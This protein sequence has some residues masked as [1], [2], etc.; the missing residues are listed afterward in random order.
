MFM[1]NL[2]VVFVP[3]TEISQVYIPMIVEACDYGEGKV[4]GEDWI[5]TSV[6]PDRE[7]AYAAFA[8]DIIAYSPV[9]GQLG[10]DITTFPIMAPVVATRDITA[11]PMTVVR[12]L[13]GQEYYRQ[14]SGPYGVKCVIIHGA[15]YKAEHAGLYEAGIILGA[16]DGEPAYAGYEKLVGK[17]G[18]AAQMMDIVSLTMVWGLI[19]LAIGNLNTIVNKRQALVSEAEV[20]GEA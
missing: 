7:E 15:D 6:M 18:D 2:H 1:K 4:Y 13:T 14:V 8:Y 19:L 10:Q 11:F 3:F 16:L 12:G 5:V 20:R 17:L 9:D